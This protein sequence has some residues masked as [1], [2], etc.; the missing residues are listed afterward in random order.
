MSRQSEKELRLRQA[1]EGLLM[2][3]RFHEFI[4]AIR[5]LKDGAVEYAVAHTTVRD[6]RET[7]AALGEVRAYQDILSLADAHMNAVEHQLVEVPQEVV[8]G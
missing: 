5:E 6:Q 2:D 8:G 7:L 1:M 3:P 4:G